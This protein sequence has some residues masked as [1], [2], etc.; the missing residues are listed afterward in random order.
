MHADWVE[1]AER[2]WVRRYDSFD[3]SCGVV[4]G[5]E[6][7]LMIDTRVSATEGSELAVHVRALSPLPVRAVVNTHVHFDHTF[8]NGALRRAWPGVPI[9]AHESVPIALPANEARIKA[10]WTDESDDPRRD[11]VLAT[12]VVAPDTLLSSVWSLD[13]GD[14]TVEV[15][16]PGRGH[17]DGDVVVRVPAGDVAYAG[18]LVEQSGPLYYGSDCWPLEW[19]QTLELVVGLIG[20]QTVV[21]PGHGDRVDKDFVLGQRGDAAD[22]A[23]QLQELAGAGVPVEEALARGQWPFEADRLEQAVRRGY[24]QLGH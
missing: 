15:V 7:L 5:T 10:Q 13:L 12:E 9:V 8:G 18:D 21:V 17:T 4:A 1:V 6:G 20:E 3:L 2:C 23:G 22:V 16:H 14:Q 24:A 19:P 11:D